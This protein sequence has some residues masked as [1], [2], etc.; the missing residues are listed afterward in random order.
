M[1]YHFGIPGPVFSRSVAPLG[2][3]PVR[4]HEHWFIYHVSQNRPGYLDLSGPKIRKDLFELRRMVVANSPTWQNSLSVALRAHF[5]IMMRDLQ[6]ATLTEFI[7]TST[8]VYSYPGQNVLYN[9]FRPLWDLIGSFHLF[10]SAA[11]TW[12]VTM[13]SSTVLYP[14][15]IPIGARVVATAAVGELA[16][17]ALATGGFRSRLDFLGLQELGRWRCLSRTWGDSR[18]QYWLYQ[19]RTHYKKIPAAIHSIAPALARLLRGLE[20]AY[21]ALQY[22]AYLT[23]YHYLSGQAADNFSWALADARHRA[24]QLPA[25]SIMG[26]Q[27]IPTLGGLQIVFA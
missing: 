1:D 4:P 23:D 26:G 17:S 5:K 14:L 27:A 9:A 3:A 8:L 25:G 24:S 21:P 12:F 15:H 2:P 10:L 16:N 20:D 6:R 7:R 13:S 18:S 22:V 11:S 19:R